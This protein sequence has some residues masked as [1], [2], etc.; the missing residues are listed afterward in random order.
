MTRVCRDCKTDKPLTAFR[1]QRECRG[2]FRPECKACFNAARLARYHANRERICAQRQAVY[3]ARGDESRRIARERYRADREWIKLNVTLKR[4][5]LTLDQYHA[6]QERQDFSCAICGDELSVGHEGAHIDH[7]HDSQKIRGLL[8]A[9]CNKG[10][11]HFRERADA[12]VAA[13]RYVAA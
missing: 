4:H 5:G 7:C 2:G 13:A 11:G 6:M 3:H 1:A 9:G 8:C 12:L 10:I